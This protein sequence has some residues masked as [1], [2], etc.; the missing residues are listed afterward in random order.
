MTFNFCSVLKPDLLD[1]YSY[2]KHRQNLPLLTTQNSC[3][4][5]RVSGSMPTVQKTYYSVSPDALPFGK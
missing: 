1:G 3:F 5:E 4:Q 2:H